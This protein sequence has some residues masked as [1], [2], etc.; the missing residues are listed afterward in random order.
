[1]HAVFI[2]QF[3]LYT[4]HNNGIKGL[5]LKNVLKNTYS[6]FALKKKVLF[7]FK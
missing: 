7:Y 6:L 5:S 2:V 4:R 3:V 1:M